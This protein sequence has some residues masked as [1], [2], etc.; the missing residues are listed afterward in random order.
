MKGRISN[1]ILAHAHYV[2]VGVSKA[3]AD[4][5]RKMGENKFS[6]PS[7]LV[8]EPYRFHLLE[9]KNIHILISLAHSPVGVAQLVEHITHKDKVAS[10]ILA[11]DTNKTASRRFLTGEGV[12]FGKEYVRD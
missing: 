9:N 1:G 10:S 2:Y 6:P 3:S 7:S 4:F 12:L 11:V 8:G 5:V